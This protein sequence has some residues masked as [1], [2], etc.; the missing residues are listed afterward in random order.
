M[1]SIVDDFSMACFFTESFLKQYGITSKGII[2]EIMIS[3]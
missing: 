2:N 1:G 3:N